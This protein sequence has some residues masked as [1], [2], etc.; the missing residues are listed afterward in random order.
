[1]MNDAIRNDLLQK[2]SQVL[3]TS[4]FTPENALKAL[5]KNFLELI[6]V[7]NTWG[8]SDKIF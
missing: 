5:N 8:K 7:R 2:S 3:K 6:P 1:M 4:V